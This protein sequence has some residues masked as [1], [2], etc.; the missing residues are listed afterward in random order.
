MVVL[1]GI[2][3]LSLLAWVFLLLFRGGFWRTDLHLESSGNAPRGTGGGPAIV[4]VIPARNEA[5]VVDVVLPSVLA[6]RYAGPFHVV[7][8]DDRSEDGT[9]DAASRA[10]ER[11]GERARLTIVRGAPLP[12]GWAGKVWAMAQGTATA[13]ARGCDHVWFTDADIEHAPG[14]LQALV[15]KA[16]K[17]KLDLVSLMAK[18]RV[19]SGWDRLLIPA[20]VYFFAKLYPF[21]FVGDPR[22]KTAGAAGGCML[23]RRATLDRAGGV[24]GIRGALIDDCA[25][26]RLIKR[27]GGRLWLGFTRSVRSIREYGTLC[28]T[29][30]MVARSAYTQLRTSPVLLLGTV[31][32]MLL[33]Y[34]AG[35]TA[36]FAGLAASAFGVPG[37]AVLASLGAGAWLVMALTFVPIL[38][39]HDVRRRTAF[40]LPWAGLLYSAMTVSSA[41]R[42]ATGRGGAWKGRVRAAGRGRSEDLGGRR[43]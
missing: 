32:G 39:H 38:R 31:L 40:L 30:D 26:G 6:Q 25:L 27:S 8:V 43:T 10:A 16:E 29:W 13:E 22:R 7:L 14:V 34:A 41:W 15:D 28:S 23:V 9:S 21:R 3:A 2:A 20:F 24:A 1:W 12:D 33:L 35:P 11:C 5:G 42:H 37:A 17:E 4:A 36:L 18:L 19:D